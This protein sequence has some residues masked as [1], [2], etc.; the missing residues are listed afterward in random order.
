[1]LP[2]NGSGKNAHTVSS[3]RQNCHISIC[4]VGNTS[5]YFSQSLAGKNIIHVLIKFQNI[6]Q[7]F[8]C[9]FV[10]CEKITV[11]AS[12]FPL[13]HLLFIL[14]LHYDRIQ[15]SHAKQCFF[16]TAAGS[17]IQ[18]RSKF[19]YFVELLIWNVHR[20]QSPAIPDHSF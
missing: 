20:I 11:F 7:T 5:Q 2:C 15:D 16:Q 19:D 18:F 9:L 8:L 3:I 1:M 17:F 12:F 10:S 13:Q 14:F 6:Q 4:I